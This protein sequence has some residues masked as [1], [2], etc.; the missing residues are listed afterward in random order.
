MRL[1]PQGAS[2]LG[3]QVPS[4]AAAFFDDWC[5]TLSW[6]LLLQ[7]LLHPPPPPPPW[8]ETI[9]AAAVH[10]ELAGSASGD[11]GKQLLNTASALIVAN[12]PQA[13]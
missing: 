4:S 2:T 11:L 3:E 12:L 1:L 5:G 10:V 9:A 6:S 8:L 7:W 13:R